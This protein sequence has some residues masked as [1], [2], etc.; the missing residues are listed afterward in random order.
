MDGEA[1]PERPLPMLTVLR[2]RSVV[3]LLGVMVLYMAAGSADVSYLFT[4]L[5]KIVFGDGDLIHHQSNV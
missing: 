3:L 1:E 5:E 2:S 4:R